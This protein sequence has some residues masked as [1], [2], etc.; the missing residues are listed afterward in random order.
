MK[1]FLLLF[2]VLAGLD[3]GFIGAAQAATSPSFTASDVTVLE[4]TGSA[5]V[6]IRKSVKEHSYSKIQLQTVDGTAKAGVDYQ[7]VSTVLTFG[8]ST[9][10]ESVPI[11][12]IARAGYQGDRSFTA[13]LTCVRYCALGT[14]AITVTIGET[15]Q[16][17]STWVAAPDRKSVV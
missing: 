8:N 11:Q 9:L 4:T 6:V 12:I 5:Q 1:R 16:P 15:E 10:S 13:K 14:S 7:A 3:P 17:S 2:A